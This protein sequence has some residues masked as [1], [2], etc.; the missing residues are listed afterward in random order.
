M[1]RKQ[2]RKRPMY[3]LATVNLNHGHDLE[4]IFSKG[5][6]YT[7]KPPS[8]SASADSP[9]NIEGAR[10]QG[11]DAVHLRTNDDYWNQHPEKVFKLTR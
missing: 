11:V 7:V 8:A 6:T 2:L 9:F 1:I 10:L 4:S 3:S 5:I